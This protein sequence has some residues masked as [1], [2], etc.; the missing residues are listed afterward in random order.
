MD[1]GI[2]GLRVLVPAVPTASGA[3]SCVRAHTCMSATWTSRRLPCSARPMQPSWGSTFQPGG[4][5]CWHVLEELISVGKVRS[6]G[7]IGQSHRV[8]ESTRLTHK[9]H[10]GRGRTHRHRSGAP[11][12]SGNPP[13]NC[14]R[15]HCAG[16]V[17]QCSCDLPGSRPPGANEVGQAFQRR[18]CSLGPGLRRWGGR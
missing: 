3:Q 5:C 15:D 17:P 10:H 8:L 13:S 4:V 11:V 2:T 7:L 1:L 12:V 16:G 18:A 6:S 14:N 9:R